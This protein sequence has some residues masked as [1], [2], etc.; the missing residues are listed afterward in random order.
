[1]IE[2]GGHVHW[3]AD[4]DDARET[5]IRI[6]REE[7]A[8]SM[9]TKG[10]SMIGEEVGVNECLEE[11]GFRPVETDLGE[12][13]IQLRH[14][15]PSHIIAPAIHLSKDQVADAFRKQHTHLP[16]DR[17]LEEPAVMLNEARE[18]LR[19][20]FLGASL[21]I[22]GA[23]ML[24]AETGSIV[25]V[26]NEGNGDLTQTLPRVQI[27]IAS[28]E[29][30]VPTARGRIHPSAR[31]GALRHRPGPLR[32]HHVHHRA[33]P[34]GDLDGPEVFHV[35]LLDN[36]R[37]RMLGGPFREMLRCIRCG[38]CINHCP[39]YGAIGG[40]AYGWVYSGPMGAVLI[41]NLIGIDEAGH[42]PNASS[43]CG[44]CEEVCPVRIPLPGCRQCR[45]PLSRAERAGRGGCRGALAR[46]TRLERRRDRGTR[47]ADPRQGLARCQPGLARGGGEWQPRAALRPGE[48]HLTQ[49]PARSSPRGAARE[50]PGVTPG[51]R[52]VS[53]A[54]PRGSGLAK[55]R[56]HHHR[57]LTHRRR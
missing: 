45:R 47:G 6:C 1:V 12:Y 9:V 54:R 29:K 15:A 10:K 36:G 33:A 17:P 27:V 49:F 4:A 35:L 48:S 46:A 19:E 7:G 39:V 25:L 53:P 38:S 40:H 37:S 28:I 44:R 14:E 57:P 32:L 3:C 56:E 42:L 11:A 13:I 51:G 23:N 22:T 8:T 20:E 41:P 16:A 5:L 50:G 31:A 52:V 34:A 24:I 55:N 2:R 30:I 21:G 43:L 26:T 18:V